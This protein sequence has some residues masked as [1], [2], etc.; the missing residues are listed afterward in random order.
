MKLPIHSLKLHGFINF[1]N[2]ANGMF[3]LHVS[4][5]KNGGDDDNHHHS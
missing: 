2:Q 3:N 5:I 4:N 1:K